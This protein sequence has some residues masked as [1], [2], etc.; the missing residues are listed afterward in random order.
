MEEAGSWDRTHLYFCTFPHM[1]LYFSLIG[2][3][4]WLGSD[5][6]GCPTLDRT[7]KH[8]PAMHMT[9][10]ALFS[11]TPSFDKRARKL[12]SGISDGYLSIGILKL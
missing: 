10:L 5:I 11:A 2:P 4:D 8:N 6:V 12:I 1:L 3:P 9:G 7:L